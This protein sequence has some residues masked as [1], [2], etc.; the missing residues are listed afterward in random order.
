MLELTKTHLSLVTETKLRCQKEN[1]LVYNDVIPSEAS[2]TPIE[3]A[4]DVAEPVPIHDVYSSAEVQK[5]V[6]PDLFLKLVPLSVHESASMYSEEKAK[7]VRAEAERVDL[8]EGELMAALEY[9]GLPASLERFKSGAA[10]QN[11]LTDPGGQV[12]TWAE[13]IRSEESRNGRLE[14]SFIKLES[15]KSKAGNELERSGRDLE[16]EA[17]ECELMRVKFGHLWEQDPSS[18]MTRSYRQDLRSHRDSLE[19]AASSDAVARG[20][21]EG[22]RRD[23]NTLIDP[24]A[25]ERTFVEAVGSGQT[26]NLLDVDLGAEEEDEESKKKVA[27]IGEALSKLSKIKKERSDILKDLKERVSCF[28]FL[29]IDLGIMFLTIFVFYI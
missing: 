9:L 11:G 29:K 24:R 21:W 15:L 1:D 17:R 23:I 13:E 3:K 5:I 4:K 16:T 19:Q 18:S 7:L 14:D 25:L 28:S 22:I 8:A 10:G 2:L 6:G 26:E 20:I 12:R 27:A